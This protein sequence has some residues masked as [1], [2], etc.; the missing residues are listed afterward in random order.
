MRYDG[1]HWSA[2]QFMLFEQCP[3]EYRRRYIDGEALE[4]TEALCFGK[5]I[6]QG[7]EAHFNGEDGEYLFRAVWKS[8]AARLNGGVHRDLTGTGLTLLDKVFALELKGAAEK[9]FKLSA[10]LVVGKPIVGAVDLWGENNVL[11]DFKTTRGRWSAERAQTEVWQPILYSWAALEES[12]E[13]PAFEYIVLNRVTGQLDRFRRQWTEEEWGE[14]WSGC[15]DRM[16]YISAAVA[17]GEME[18]HG[19]HGYCPECGARWSHDHVC[20]EPHSKRIRL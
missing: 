11:Y 15:Y 13:L 10:D 19:N 8:E 16:R 3:A 14:Q 9:E 18:C 5:A 2:S 4:L 6:H 20:D 1:P 7:L 12:G 17:A